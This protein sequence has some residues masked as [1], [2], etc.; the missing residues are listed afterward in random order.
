MSRE[1]QNRIRILIVEDQPIC[2]LGIKMSL[3]QA[4]VPCVVEGEVEDV[5]HAVAFL[6]QRSRDIDL[7][8]LDYVLPDGTGKDVI[9]AAKEIC[10]QVKIVILSGEAGG[11]I[12]K[13]LM[14]SGISGFMS[15]NV[16]PEELSQV[17]ASVMQGRNYIAENKMLL[18]DDVKADFE[19]L[20]TLTRR[21]MELISHCATG[22][23][24]KQIAEEMNIAPHSVENMKSVLFGKLAVR[25][26]SELI[27]YA[28]RV[29]LVG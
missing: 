23:T 2:R 1:P 7:I 5:S 15:K 8:L 18:Q 17:L 28:F 14:D 3:N 10:P 9:E 13:Q 21:E 24:T 22:L 6:E 26:T 4:D 27:L 25:S 29:G 16:K 12:V 20:K 11:A 19:T